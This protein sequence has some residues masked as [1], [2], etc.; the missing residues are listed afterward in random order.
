MGDEKAV[1]YFSVLSVDLMWW[2]GGGLE[3]FGQIS[4]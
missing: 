4:G 2:G 3:I 1:S